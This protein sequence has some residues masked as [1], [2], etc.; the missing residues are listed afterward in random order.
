MAFSGGRRREDPQRHHTQYSAGKR[1]S[2]V[3]FAGGE[4]NLFEKASDE[5]RGEE[6]MG[7]FHSHERSGMI[8]ASQGDLLG[9]SA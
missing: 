1:R 2:I 8:R 6:G 3:L 4:G 5:D 7:R 9:K